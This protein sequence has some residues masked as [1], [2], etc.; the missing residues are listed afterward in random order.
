MKSKRRALETYILEMTKEEAEWL[1][2]L[3]QNHI[4]TQNNINCDI[5]NFDCQAIVKR[6]L[7][8]NLKVKYLD[9]FPFDIHPDG[10]KYQKEGDVGID[11][12]ASIGLP[13]IE[14]EPG[15]EVNIPTGIAIEP[16][17][18]Y[19]T[20]LMPR[21]SLSKTPLMFRNSFGL[22]DPNYRGEMI[23]PLRNVGKAS[24]AIERGERVA[25]LV[26][27]PAIIANIVRVEQLS[28][29]VRGDKGFGSSG[30]K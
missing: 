13:Y 11:I 24:Y 29:T 19:A 15:E 9:N 30:R 8:P 2:S 3:M 5:D 16:D 26:V 6:F 25:Q 21:S 1:K 18:G 27:I 4:P 28:E 7:N 17:L 23:I 20:F 12:V 14:V 22:I 10:V